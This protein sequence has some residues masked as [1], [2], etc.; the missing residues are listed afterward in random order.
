MSQGAEE[1]SSPIGEDFYEI[2][3]LTLRHG[4]MNRGPERASV[5]VPCAST[6]SRFTATLMR[7][8]RERSRGGARRES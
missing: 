5:I 7:L 1:P 3:G 8:P 6:A 4:R 2:G